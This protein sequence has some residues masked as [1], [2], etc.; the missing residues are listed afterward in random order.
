M[1]LLDGVM[2][3][4]VVYP[5]VDDMPAGFSKVWLQTY[6]RQK[7][8]FDGVVFSDDLSMQGA[9]FIGDF[10]AR[11][12]AALNAGCDMVLVC[13]NPDAAAQVIDSLPS[14]FPI[15]PRLTKLAKAPSA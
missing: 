15:N 14:E 8:Q 2:P 1:G 6:L 9:A 7:M 11:A 12:N 10:A 13:N 5:Q 3:A 4:H